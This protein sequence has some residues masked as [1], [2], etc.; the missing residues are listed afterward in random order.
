MQNQTILK[1]LKYIFF[2]VVSDFIAIQ[3]EKQCFADNNLKAPL[4][5][6]A[7]LLTWVRQMTSLAEMQ[8]IRLYLCHV[9]NGTEYFRFIDFCP[10]FCPVVIAAFQ[11]ALNS[12]FTQMMYGI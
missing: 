3:K 12:C 2:L 5:T 11:K 10:S 7:K 8:E 4:V 6:H 9:F 1:L